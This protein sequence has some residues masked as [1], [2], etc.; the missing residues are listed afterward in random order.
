MTPDD[1]EEVEHKRIVAV[2]WGPGDPATT[3]VL[4]DDAGQLIDTMFAGSLSGPIR[5]SRDGL[6]FDSSK[7]GSCPAMPMH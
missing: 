3:F 1:D 7:V 5:R 6:F 4:L 2:C